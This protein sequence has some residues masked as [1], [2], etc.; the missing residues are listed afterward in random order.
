M[1]KSEDRSGMRAYAK[2]TDC[3]CG[4]VDG[5]MLVR[6]C[7]AMLSFTV[8]DERGSD[9][10]GCSLDVEDAKSLCDLLDAYLKRVSP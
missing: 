7:G 5:V 10:V 4:G 8:D 9:T 1:S 6:E 3:W 2:S